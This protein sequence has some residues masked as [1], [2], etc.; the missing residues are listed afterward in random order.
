MGSLIRNARDFWAGVLFLGLG[1]AFVII[2]QDYRMGTARSMGP[3]YF[4]VVLGALLALVGAATIIRG[5]IRRGEPLKGFALK[6]AV[7][8]LGSAVSFGLLLRTAGLPVAVAAMVV[9]GG[10]ASIHFRWTWFSLVA[11]GL[12]AFCSLIFIQGLGLPIPLVGWWFQ[13]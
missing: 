7:L 12:A 1:G 9:V 4:P 5:L 3:A 6:E 10:L 11:V 13:R 2:G 8:I